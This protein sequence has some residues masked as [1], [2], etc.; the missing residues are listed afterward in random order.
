MPRNEYHTVQ[1][2]SN[3]NSVD[4]TLMC[5]PGGRGPL[6][7]NEGWWALFS[8]GTVHIAVQAIVHYYSNVASL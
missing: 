2:G 6:K 3:F 1:G 5:D 7:W 4:E 8:C